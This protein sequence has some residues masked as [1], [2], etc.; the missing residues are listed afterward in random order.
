MKKTYYPWSLRYLSLSPPTMGMVQA[1][2][3][4]NYQ[5]LLRLA[6]DLSLMEG[7]HLSSLGRGIDL[8]L[9]IYEQTPYTSLIHL[10]YFFPHA[11]GHYPDPDASLRV[12]HDFQQVDVMDMRQSALPLQRWGGHPTLEQRWKINLFLSKWLNYCNTQG[13]RFSLSAQVVKGTFDIQ[14]VI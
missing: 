4:E 12:Y 9:E 1:Q 7:K 14:E 11:V 2:S 10:T 8:H 5:H 13:H 6:P 3:E